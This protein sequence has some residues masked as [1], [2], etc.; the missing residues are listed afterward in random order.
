M[1]PGIYTLATPE[2]PEPVPALAVNME[3]SES[4]LSPI[5]PADIPDILGVDHLTLCDGKEDLLRKIEEHRV[6]RTFGEHLLWLAL[7]VAAV[8]FFY[9][10]R[11]L[12]AVPKLSEALRLESSGKVTGHGIAAAGE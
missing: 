4:N 5:R 6:G 10:N 12:Q 1:K 7:L 11:L 9:A 8:E 3:R 2:R